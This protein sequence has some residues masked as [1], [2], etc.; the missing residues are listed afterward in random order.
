MTPLEARKQLLIAES[1]INR[2]RLFEDMAALKVDIQGLK[3][4]AKSFGAIASTVAAL[5]AGLLT[6]GRDKT[7]SPE[8]KPAWWRTAL[9]VA[10]MITSAL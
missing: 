7:R 5:A 4:R 2:A 9:K 3:H 8:A 1:E 10:G 6:S